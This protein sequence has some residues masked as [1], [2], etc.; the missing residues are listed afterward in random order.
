MK[1]AVL[2]VAAAFSIIGC[3]S[4]TDP[5]QVGQDT[6]MIGASSGTG[7]DSNTTLLTETLK[8]ANAFCAKQGKLAELQTSKTSGAQGWS[9]QNAQAMFKCVPAQ[10]VN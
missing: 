6:Y 9:M 4:V 2:V 1:M 8:G 7:F 10:P 5:I 3:L